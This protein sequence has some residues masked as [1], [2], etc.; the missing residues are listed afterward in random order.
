M[1]SKYKSLQPQPNLNSA[2][3]GFSVS[4]RI[5]REHQSLRLFGDFDK[6][7]SL[8]DLSREE[9]RC[10]STFRRQSVA[11]TALQ[12]LSVSVPQGFCGVPK[13]RWI[14][15]N[16][17]ETRRKSNLFGRRTLGLRASTGV[18][19]CIGSGGWAR[20]FRWHVHCELPVLETTSTCLVL[21]AA[22]RR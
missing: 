7:P 15:H 13:A 5:S 17:A 4:I 8:P 14:S 9:L 16:A 20:G 1:R 2:Q 19:F 18:L 22:A 10:P 3:S 21:Y 12:Q 6:S 11:R